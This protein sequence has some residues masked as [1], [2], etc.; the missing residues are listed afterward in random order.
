VLVLPFHETCGN[1]IISNVVLRMNSWRLNG[2]QLQCV[3]NSRP[4]LQHL[5]LNQA[6]DARQ[7]GASCF[8]IDRGVLF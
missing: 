1:L 4:A 3:P 8:L 5:P 2:Q 7:R 6:H